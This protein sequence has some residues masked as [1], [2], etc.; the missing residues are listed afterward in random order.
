MLGG[1][2]LWT[3]ENFPEQEKGVLPLMPLERVASGVA[4]LLG[5][6]ERAAWISCGPGAGWGVQPVR[7]S[8]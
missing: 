5:L 8:C 1:R 7:L 3:R 4:G 2:G 6:C